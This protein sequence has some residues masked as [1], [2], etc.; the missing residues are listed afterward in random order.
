MENIC[1]GQYVESKCQYFYLKQILL[2]S[3]EKTC[4]SEVL[5]IWSDVCWTLSPKEMRDVKLSCNYLKY[6]HLNSNTMLWYYKIKNVQVC[7][8][9]AEIWDLWSLKTFSRIVH[10]GQGASKSERPCDVQAC[11]PASSWYYLAFQLW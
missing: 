10:L 7:L 5:S 1:T 8:T 9:Q 3:V 2:K 4:S 6:W 11:T